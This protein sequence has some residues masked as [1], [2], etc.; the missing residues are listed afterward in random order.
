MNGRLTTLLGALAISVA[1]LVP[2]PA[3]AWDDPPGISFFYPLLTRRPVIERE[4]EFTVDHEKGV[5]GRV[6]EARA[7]IEWPIL[8]RWQ[9]ELEVPLIFLQERERTAQSGFGDLEIQSKVLVFDSIDPP[10]L[11]AIGVEGRLPSG[12]ERR[13][14]GGEAAIEPFVAAG[15]ALGPFDLLAQVAYEWN[16]NSHVHGPREQELTAGAALGWRVHRKFTPLVELTTVTQTRG[17]NEEGLRGRTQVYVT[18]G[19]NVRPLPGTTFRLGI[20]LPVT[21]ARKFDYALRS[22]FVIEF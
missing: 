8:P 1:V 16:L 2:R 17:D 10:A 6:T 13:G 20:E 5:G 22:G 21:D 12:S 4:L 11:V 18:P 14:L 19:F 3:Q 7:A 15:V 9:V